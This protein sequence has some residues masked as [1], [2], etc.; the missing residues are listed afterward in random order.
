MSFYLAWR[1]W[2]SNKHNQTLA[3]ITYG[4]EKVLS[5][6]RDVAIE[7]YAVT[8]PDGKG[9]LVLNLR[10]WIRISSHDRKFRA[11]D[12]ECGPPFVSICASDNKL[13]P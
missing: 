7:G 1:K 3:D 13:E 11:R 6:N 4:F 2:E 8:S 12:Q 5:G 10:M 9:S